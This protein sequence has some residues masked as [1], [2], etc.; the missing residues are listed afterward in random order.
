MLKLI[1]KHLLSLL[2]CLS[3]LAT[4]GLTCQ[5]L[6]KTSPSFI[7][8]VYQS[9]SVRRIENTPFKSFQNLTD[10]FLQELHQGNLS[11]SQVGKSLDYI[12]KA[13]PKGQ[14][15]PLKAFE[16]LDRYILNLE[17][18]GVSYKIDFLMSSLFFWGRLATPSKEALGV[19]DQRLSKFLENLAS[20][21]K[22]KILI[23]ALNSSQ[24]Q[25]SPKNSLALQ[26]FL[27]AHESEITP[28][29]LIS[30]TSSK[31]IF[32]PDSINKAFRNAIKRR[33]QA[34]HQFLKNLDRIKLL[35]GLYIFGLEPFQ[36][37]AKSMIELVSSGLQ[38]L[39]EQ[40]RGVLVDVTNYMAAFIPDLEI[41][42]LRND[43]LD[44]SENQSPIEQDVHMHLEF[45]NIDFEAEVSFDFMRSTA[46]FY[47]PNKKA[48]V[49]IDG[50][51]HYYID[52]DGQRHL[53]P[54][55]VNV[56]RMLKK[57]GYKSIRIATHTENG[58]KK[59]VEMILREIFEALK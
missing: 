21:K 55:D 23:A 47:F 52:P 49:F 48:V 22:V 11:P 17:S 33:L 37:E 50:P 5:N 9:Q 54:S 31:G 42:A 43:V 2:I 35:H 58:S 24:T 19:I 40:F 10:R 45:S 38:N 26:N 32:S 57:K 3:P 44:N 14:R 59:S 39:D 12:R 16:G 6:L 28:D 7:E 51:I 53:K 56:N 41:K 27:I 20:I 34:S 4:Y 29:I 36:H 46:D 13:K 15:I 18:E 8:L 1:Y 30:L 25:L